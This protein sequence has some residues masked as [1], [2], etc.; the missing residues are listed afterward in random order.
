MTGDNVA[1]VTRRHDASTHCNQLING[2]EL[3]RF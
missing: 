3:A 2:I 1:L